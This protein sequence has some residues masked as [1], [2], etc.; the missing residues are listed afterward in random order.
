MLRRFFW[1]FRTKIQQ[2]FKTCSKENFN[3]LILLAY[4]CPLASSITYVPI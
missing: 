4:N 2:A 3:I 1:T